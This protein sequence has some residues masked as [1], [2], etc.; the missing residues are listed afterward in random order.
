MWKDIISLKCRLDGLKMYTINTKASTNITKQRAIAN[1]P[2]KEIKYFKILGQSE[3]RHKK[4]K[5]IKK[6]KWKYTL[7]SR[8]IRFNIVKMCILP[9]TIY[10]FNTIPIKIPMALLTEIKKTTLKFIWNHRRPQVAK[11]VLKKQ[12]KTGGIIL[13]C[14]KI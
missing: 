8:V 3:G 6:I 4:R 10:G 12:N 7:C 13:F 1:K 14:F 9:K 5:G 2:T 11:A